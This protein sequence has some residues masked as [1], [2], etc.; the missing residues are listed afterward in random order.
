MINAQRELVPRRKGLCA[1]TCGVLGPSMSFLTVFA[2]GKGRAPVFIQ[3]WFMPRHTLSSS[4]IFW[5]SCIYMIF[6][7]TSEG[8]REKD[9]QTFCL[10]V[11]V[12]VLAIFKFFA[13]GCV[14]CHRESESESEKSRPLPP[15]PQAWW[16]PQSL[17][18][19]FPGILST[20][21]HGLGV[22]LKP[23]GPRLELQT[24]M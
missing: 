13:I 15:L 24:T 18:L 6:F 10:F 11:V 20:H 5:R 17:L 19:H 1:L 21:A 7:I 3:T 23:S 2:V 9:L 14:H 4:F 22:S 12:F 8:P 16:H